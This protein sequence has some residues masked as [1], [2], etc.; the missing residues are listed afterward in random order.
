MLTVFTQTGMGLTAAVS[1]LAYPGVTYNW[2]VGATNAGGTTWS[3]T[4]M[5]LTLTPPTAP[6]LSTPTNVFTNGTP[7]TLSWTST[8]SA[9]A[10]TIQVSTSSLFGSTVFSQSGL[11]TGFKFTPVTG[12]YNYCRVDVTN[13]AATSGWS[14]TLVL[15]P[16]VSVAYSPLRVENYTFSMKPGAIR[17]SLPSAQKVEFSLF[18]ILGREAM[19]FNKLQAAGSYSVDIKGTTLAAGQYIVR[20]KAGTFEKQAIMMLTR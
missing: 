8:A 5:F 9:T 2:R 11:T 17:Y 6:T 3:S 1:G 4:W 20:F 13:P 14:T 18:D 10:Y 12:I 15:T 19:S 7:V 16:S